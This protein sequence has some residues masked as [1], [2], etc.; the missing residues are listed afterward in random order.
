MKGLIRAGSDPSG[1][2]RANG[3]TQRPRK[4]ILTDAITTPA[5]LPTARFPSGSSPSEKPLRIAV[6]APPWFEI[7]PPSYGGIEVMCATMIE[8]LVGRGHHVTLLGVGENGTKAHFRRTLPTPQF[9]NIAMALPEAHHTARVQ[10]ILDNE[11]FDVI[12]DHTIA[13]PMMAPYRKAPT[14]TT[15]HRPVSEV[16]DFYSTLGNDVNLVSVSHSQRAPRPD[17]NWLGTVHNG[18]TLDQFTYNPEP[19]NYALWLARFNPEKGPDLAIKMCQEAGVPLILAGKLNESSEKEYFDEVI[20]PMLDDNVR[21]VINASRAEVV[22]LVRNAQCL[23]HSVRWAEP[24]GMVMAEAMSCGTPVLGLRRGAVPE[25]VADGVTGWVR[26]E[27]SE[28]AELLPH[29]EKL[30][31]RE[32]RA[33]VEKRFSADAVAAG[34]ERIYRRAIAK[35][36]KKARLASMSAPIGA[37][38]A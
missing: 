9:E 36:R 20:K 29:A 35:H 8:G 38:A 17:L 1:T 30:D 22:E 3:S 33:R 7:P 5:L 32:C 12:H 31:R 2:S 13:G 6:V 26:D 37:S 27:P 16:G 21:V 10:Q 23:I 15:V 4:E 28:L 18:I 14:V 34:Y 24:F 19:E 25:V 11:E